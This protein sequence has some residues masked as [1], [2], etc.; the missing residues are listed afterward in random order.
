MSANRFE[1]TPGAIDRIAK[2]EALCNVCLQAAQS[3]ASG[4]ASL[5]PSEGATYTANVVVG[6]RRAHAR[7]YAQLPDSFSQRKKW[8][9]S[10]PLFRVQPRI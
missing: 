10:M 4:A 7:A 3:I 5:D 9:E 2:S 1:W 6:Q 8:R